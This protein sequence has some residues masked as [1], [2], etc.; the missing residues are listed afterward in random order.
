MERMR[1]IKKSSYSRH[2]LLPFLWKT[3]LQDLTLTGIWELRFQKGSHY[4]LVRVAR[5]FQIVCINNMVYEQQGCSFWRLEFGLCTRQ[6][7]PTWPVQNKNPGRWVSNEFPW[8]STTP[9]LS[10]SL[11]W[12]LSMSCV[13]PLEVFSGLCPMCLFLLLILLLIHSL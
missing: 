6:G 1:T 8:L 2:E 10:N 9:T 5:C 13:I 7:M 11:L 3:L 4:E 12:E